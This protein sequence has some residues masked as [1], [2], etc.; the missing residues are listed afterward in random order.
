MQ[1]KQ[2]PDAEHTKQMQQTRQ[3]F[4]KLQNMTRKLGYWEVFLF[5]E[6]A[7][8]LFETMLDETD[9]KNSQTNI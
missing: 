6:K 7:S 9:Q 5:I 1:T 8:E 4:K 2:L 3:L